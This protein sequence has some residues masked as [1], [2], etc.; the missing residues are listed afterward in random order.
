MREIVMVPQEHIGWLVD[1]K[2]SVLS[3]R[4]IRKK[5]QAI[6]CLLPTVMDPLHDLFMFDVVRRDLPRNFGVLQPAILEEVRDAIDTTMGL[7]ID[8]WREVCLWQTMRT[9]IKKVS[10]RVLFDL[11]LSEDQGFSRSMDAFSKWLGSGAFIAGQLVPWPLRPFVGSLIAIPVYLNMKSALRALVPTVKKRMDDVKRDPSFKDKEQNNFMSWFATAVLNADIAPSVK[12][13]EARAHR[14]MALVIARRRTYHECHMVNVFLDLLSSAPGHKYFEQLREEAQAVFRSETDWMD[15]TSLTKLPLADSTIRE[16]LRRNPINMKGLLREVLPEDGVTLPDGSRIPRG[17]WIG[18]AQRSVHMDER[19]YSNANGYEPFRFYRPS[20]QVGEPVPKIE[21]LSEKAS[22]YRKN[23]NLPTTSDVFMAWGHGRHACP[24]RWFATHLLKLI[25]SSIVI[26]YDIESLPDRP[27]NDFHGDFNIP[28]RTATI[29]VRRRNGSLYKGHWKKKE[30]L[31]NALRIFCSDPKGKKSSVVAI[32]S[33]PQPDATTDNSPLAARL[34]AQHVSHSTRTKQW[35][36]KDSSETK[37]V[38]LKETA[39]QA[40]SASKMVA[41]ASIPHAQ[42]K[43]RV[44]NLLRFGFGFG[45][46]S[47]FGSKTEKNGT[48][49]SGPTIDYDIDGFTVV[50]VLLEPGEGNLGMNGPN[51]FERSTLLIRDEQNIFDTSKFGL[52]II[53]LQSIWHCVRD[54]TVLYGNATARNRRLQNRPNLK[55][56]KHKE[57]AAKRTKVCNEDEHRFQIM[58][59][60]LPQAVLS[61]VHSLSSDKSSNKAPSG[62]T[63]KDE[64]ARALDKPES[65]L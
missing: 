59:L 7:E 41:S 19:F 13:P 11:P 63:E 23:V 4:E 8:G 1:Q 17:A 40:S 9:I 2:D 42:P 58:T 46:G 47:G 31:G 22:D 24:G 52:L 27:T 65:D 45:S 26:N 62:L 53:L 56:D 39:F 12:T 55:R 20:S 10:N 16:S 57:K 37:I 36:E 60:F 35:L 15:P 3:V 44:W 43:L 30:Y 61:F 48:A 29:K 51:N 32:H 21:Q 28:S 64:E 54:R 33:Q 34:H 38:N 50:E 6:E 25:V 18:T 14:L 5:N 49:E